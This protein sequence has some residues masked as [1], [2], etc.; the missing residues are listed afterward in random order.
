MNEPVSPTKTVRQ[1][2]LVVVGMFGFGFAMVPLYD[3]MCE[4]T[5][6]NGK[7]AGP[8][9]SLET[10]VVDES[11]TVTV[12][13]LANNNASMPWEFRPEVRKMVVHP[14]KMNEMNFYVRNVTNKT[15]SA[16]AVP[17]VTPF[18]A[19]EYMHKTECFC[20][21]QQELAQGEDLDM[22]LRF[23]IDQNIPTEVKTLTLSYTLYDITEQVEL[24]ALSE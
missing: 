15:M 16:Q 13:F 20:F 24:A 5:G 19:A 10:Q 17:S 22:P 3:I 6:F 14:G 21:E 18:N 11:R 9:Q 7:T 1:L 8:Y 12:Q 4:I 23:I 2:L